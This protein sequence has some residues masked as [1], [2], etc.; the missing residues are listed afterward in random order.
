MQLGLALCRPSLA[1]ADDA[2]APQATVVCDHVA[3]AGR[4]RCEVEARVGPG[5]SIAWGDVALLEIPSFATALRG[6][7]GPHDASVREPGLWRWVFA[8]VARSKGIGDLNGRVR[9]VVCNDRSCRARLLE[10]SG[11]V[12][13]G[14]EAP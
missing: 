14:N 5:E 11:K 1:W 6:R 10:V 12:E 4:V 13:V 3:G 7:I 9:I 2:G 8:L